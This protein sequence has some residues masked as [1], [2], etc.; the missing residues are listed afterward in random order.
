[1][2]VGAFDA[3][4]LA[5]VVVIVVVGRVVG[6]GTVVEAV[7]PVCELL[8]DV[9]DVSDVTKMV[10]VVDVSS[11]EL[12]GAGEVKSPVGSELEATV[13]A[14]SVV[15]GVEI[16]SAGELGVVVSKEDADMVDVGVEV[17]VVAS[18]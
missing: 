8:V 10:V 4:D 17:E 12:D 5:L 13:D 16:V 1:M 14:D 6:T 15:V 7:W 18:T 9:G 2:V 11:T 3:E